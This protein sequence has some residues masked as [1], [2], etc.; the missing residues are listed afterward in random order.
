MVTMKKAYWQPWQPFLRL[1]YYF[2]NNN[3]NCDLQSHI[4]RQQQKHIEKRYTF[5]IAINKFTI[6]VAIVIQSHFAN[7]E[8]WSCKN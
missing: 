2:E 4:V 8:I 6:K 7:C 3:C 1:G 5:A